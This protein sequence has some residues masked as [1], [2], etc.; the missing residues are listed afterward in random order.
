MDNNLLEAVAN[1]DARTYRN[2]LD[3]ANL[4]RWQTAGFPSDMYKWF[5]E[6]I[7]KHR[8]DRWEIEFKEVC[9]QLNEKLDESHDA[10]LDQSLV[11]AQNLKGNKVEIKF[12]TAMV[13]ESRKDADKRGYSLTWAERAMDI[14]AN[15][16]L[17]KK[18][19]WQQVKPD[20]AHYGLFSILHGN[21]AVHYWMPYHLLSK[22]PGKDWVQEGK[23]PMGIQH[24]GHNTEGQVDLKPRFHELFFLDKT[25]GSPFITDLSKYDL[26]K[27][28]NLVY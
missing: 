21:G 25:Y 20:C 22:R 18:G 2:F 27:Y 1:M 11:D 8:G 24:K 15:G 4:S 14:P 19:T 13:P 6:G 28:D 3:Q 10:T 7:S 12:Y 16:D 26:A 23:V 17:P 5:K 9:A